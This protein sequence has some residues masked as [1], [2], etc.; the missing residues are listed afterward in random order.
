[1]IDASKSMSPAASFFARSV[2]GIR[3]VSPGSLRRPVGG[4][5]GG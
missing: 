5:L 4:R 1:M 3:Y 2:G